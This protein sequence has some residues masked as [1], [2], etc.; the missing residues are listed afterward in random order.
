M[1]FESLRDLEP[2]IAKAFCLRFQDGSHDQLRFAGFRHASG[3]V[4]RVSANADLVPESITRLDVEKAKVAV[5]IVGI[6]SAAKHDPD[7]LDHDSSGLMQ[8]A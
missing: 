6:I 5:L 7:Y 2:L 8:P 3:S 4:F 1:K